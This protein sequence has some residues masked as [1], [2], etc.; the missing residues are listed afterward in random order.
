MIHCSFNGIIKATPQLR[1]SEKSGRTWCRIEVIVAAGSPDVVSVLCFGGRARRVCETLRAGDKVAVEGRLSL[2]VRD[3]LSAA[4]SVIS[5]SVEQ[6]G[7]IPRDVASLRARR[8]DA[9]SVLGRE[10]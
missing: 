4:L 2:W 7:D 9:E 10:A 1:H 6:A 3:D 8:G 5:T